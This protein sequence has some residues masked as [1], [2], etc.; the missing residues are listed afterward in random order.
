MVDFSNVVIQ[1]ALRSN[2][3]RIYAGLARSGNL[4]QE[5]LP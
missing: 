4:N 3:G 5:Q 2:V 1:S